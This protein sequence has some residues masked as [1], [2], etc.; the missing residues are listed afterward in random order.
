VIVQLAMQ[1]DIQDLGGLQRRVDLTVAASEVAQ[2]VSQRLARIAR[3]TSMPGFRRGKVPLKIV[4]ASYGSQVQAEV[5]REKIGSALSSALDASKLRLAGAPRLEPKSADDSDQIAFSATFEVYPEIE[6]GATCPSSRLHRYTWRDRR[7][8]RRPDPGN[9][10]PPSARSGRRS[11]AR[12]PTAIASRSISAERSTLNHSKAEKRKIF[13]STWVK[14]GCCRTSSGPCAD[15]APVSRRSSRVTFPPDYPAAKAAGRTGALRADSQARG[16]DRPAAGSMRTSPARWA[17]RTA[18]CPGCAASSGPIW[19]ARV[20]SRLRTRTREHV[21]ASLSQGAQFD[22]PQTLVDEEL[23]RLGRIAAGGAAA[24]PAAPVSEALQQAARYRVRLGLL[25][26]ELVA[27][28]RLQPRQDQV[29]KAV[30][31][32]AQSYENPSEVIH[33]YLGNRE[34]LAEI[35]AGLTEDNVVNWAL[36]RAKVSDVSVPFDELMGGRT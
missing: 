16:G 13:R 24:D 14:D 29:R 11:S 21:F 4:A 36:A 31:T 9:C 12:R 25:I 5:M 22:V 28:N 7:G 34:R 19:S 18:T 27:R 8:E 35:E 26:G 10:S 3:Q 15:C 23:Q 30:E 17:W 6:A 2:E 20:A 33:W 32:I 1:T